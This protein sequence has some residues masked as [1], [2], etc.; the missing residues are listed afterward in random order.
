MDEHREGIQ[1]DES[2]PPWER[3]GCFRM[4]CEPHRGT[5]L[6]WLAFASLAFGSFAL[7]PCCGWEPGLIGIPF[8]LCIRQLTKGDLAKMRAGLMDPAGEEDTAQAMSLSTYG[9]WLSIVGTIISGGACLL[10]SWIT[11]PPPR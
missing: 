7:F 6:W 8:G 5:L 11:G 3:P 9:L 2:I 4:D 1:D 10:F